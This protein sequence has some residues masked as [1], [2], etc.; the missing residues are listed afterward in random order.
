MS[1]TSELEVP[2][3]IDAIDDLGMNIQGFGETN[4]PWAP[5]NRWKYN[6]LMN[7]RFQGSRTLY[8]STPLAHDCMS[9]PGG[10]VLTVTSY[11]TGR[12]VKSGEDDLGRFC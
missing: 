8:S 1:L 4:R 7:T 3:K 12:I 5:R 2:Y 9:Q 6:H 11:T 10:T